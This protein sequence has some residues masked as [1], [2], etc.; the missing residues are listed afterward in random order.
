[1]NRVGI[2]PNKDASWRDSLRGIAWN[3]WLFPSERERIGR[4]CEG[5]LSEAEYERLYR[6]YVEAIDERFGYWRNSS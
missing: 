6:Y 2:Y 4:L 5:S 3:T 1:M